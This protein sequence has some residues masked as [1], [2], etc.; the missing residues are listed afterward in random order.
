MY[1]KPLVALAAAAMFLGACGGED[2][3]ETQ[4]GSTEPPATET[5]AEVGEA[6]EAEQPAEVAEETGET[7]VTAISAEGFTVDHGCGFGFAKGSDAQDLGLII[8][9]TGPYDE[10]GPDLAAP[11][12]LPNDDWSAEVQTGADLFSNWCDDAVE[13]DDPIPR[14]DTTWTVTSGTI[15]V[16]AIEPAGA[17]ASVDATLAGLVLESADGER[18]ELKPIQL[19]NELWGI[20][21]G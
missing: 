1:Q 20:F 3:A 19:S 21:A 17:G 14:I 7:V 12:V 18:L 10:A 13:E 5:T 6:A 2:D 8:F 9:S 16:T 15:T 4:T 11:I